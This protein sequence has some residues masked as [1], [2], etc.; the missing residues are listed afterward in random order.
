MTSPFIEGLRGIEIGRVTIHPSFREEATFDDNIF[1]NDSGEGEGRVA[2]LIFNTRPGIGVGFGFKVVQIDARYIA[3]YRRY[4]LNP[5][6]STTGLEGDFQF[7]VQIADLLDFES[8]VGGRRG[9]RLFFDFNN[10]LKA[11]TQPLDD[12]FETER[13]ARLVE[14]YSAKGGYEISKKTQ[15][16][17]VHNLDYQE[18]LNH[19]FERIDSLTL[20]I[21]LEAKHAI[22]QRIDLVSESRYG[23]S[24][25]F[26]DELNDSEFLEFLG[27]AEGQ[28]SRRLSF[29]FLAGYHR[30]TN[31]GGGSNE[32]DSDADDF[33][34][35]GSLTYEIGPATQ[36]RV[37]LSR[38]VQLASGSNF[39]V[40]S[41]GRLRFTH[42]FTS[43]ISGTLQGEVQRQEPSR[44]GDSTQYTAS[45]KMEYRLTDW[46]FLDLEYQFRLND[47]EVPSADFYNNRVTLGMNLTF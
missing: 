11:D 16:A 12:L 9:S 27:G 40:T 5:E 4:I 42:Q 23:Q 30:R 35:R 3:Q 13:V 28:F 31:L 44:G 39:K 47:S 37:D 33:V 20:D 38:T 29:S 18:A 6:E 41:I 7:D 43:K 24:R 45:A 22:T 21:G 25:F 2:D 8:E 1:L 34:G 32:D 36:A 26:E 14:R 46:M 19:D 17:L 15:V 10:D